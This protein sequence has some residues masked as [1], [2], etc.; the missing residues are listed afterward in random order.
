MSDPV[1][2]SGSPPREPHYLDVLDEEAAVAWAYPDSAGPAK[3][4]AAI[5]HRSA[6]WLLRQ[7]A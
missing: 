1:V 3:T 2:R 4:K 6:G 7:K 5:P